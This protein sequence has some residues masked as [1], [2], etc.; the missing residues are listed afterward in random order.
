MGMEV[1]PSARE[2]GARWAGRGVACWTVNESVRVQV[3]PVGK[4]R[5]YARTRGR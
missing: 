3:G 4:E 5:V 1:L 2:Q